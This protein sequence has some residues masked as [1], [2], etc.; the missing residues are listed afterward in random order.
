MAQVAQSLAASGSWAA[1]PSSVDAFL[2]RQL[3]RVRT[4]LE[5][6]PALL[7]GTASET[8]GTGAASCSGSAAH[9]VDGGTIGT[10]GM[11][12]QHAPTPVADADTDM[13]LGCSDSDSQPRPRYPPAGW[14]LPASAAA[15]AAA[16]HHA[17]AC[18]AAFVTVLWPPLHDIVLKGISGKCLAVAARALAAALRADSSALAPILP[19]VLEAAAAAFS[20]PGGASFGETL[21]S[22]LE[23][24]AES[25]GAQ[26]LAC[27]RAVWAAP[28]VRA[29]HSLRQSLLL[30]RLVA[31]AILRCV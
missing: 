21:S 12:T 23:A 24:F 15:K 13:Q 20:R 9:T 8:G 18:L 27:L 16:S 4:M 1:L 19:Q 26:L 31:V 28:Q 17:S 7:A 30:V 10:A 6:P 2:A 25:Q 22:C 3:G 11:G 29:K 14:A 5:P